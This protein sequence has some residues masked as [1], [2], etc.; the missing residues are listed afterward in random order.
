M[1]TPFELTYAL[2]GEGRNVKYW[3]ES[4]FTETPDKPAGTVFCYDTSA[5]FILNVLVERLTGKP[6]MDYLYDD[7]YE[8]DVIPIRDNADVFV[9]QRI[10]MLE[11]LESIAL[12][13]VAG[14]EA[15]LG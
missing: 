12:D 9:E 2:S 1:A 13:P 5:S 6:F 8:D 10:Q 4:F 3:V 14:V 7:L 15:L 11:V